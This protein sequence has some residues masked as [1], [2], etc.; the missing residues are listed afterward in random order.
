MTSRERPTSGS[1]STVAVPVWKSPASDPALRSVA[2][3]LTS[4][5]ANGWEKIL[6]LI[7]Q[8]QRPALM[9]LARQQGLLYAD[10]V[11]LSSASGS[12]DSPPPLP[13]VVDFL[14]TLKNRLDD[15]EPV[16]V[17]PAPVEDLELDLHQRL[18]VARALATPDICLILGLPGTGKSRVVA[19]IVRQAGQRNQRVLLLGQTAAALERVLARLESV[20]SIC[21]LRLLGPGETPENLPVCSRRLTL[22]ERAR[23][24]R[25]QT[26]PSARE[27]HRA[28]ELR[29]AS[30]QR[31]ADVWPELVELARQR[32]QLLRELAHLQQL[33]ADVPCA[34]EEIV[35]QSNMASASPL[36]KH[37]D[38]LHRLTH[39]HRQHQE[40]SER[41]GSAIAQAEKQRSKLIAD[42]DRVR[43][44]LQQIE[45]L[46]QA[47][48]KGRW[49]LPAWWRSLVQAQQLSRYP[50]LQRQHA[51]WQQRLQ[52]CE[53]QLQQLQREQSAAD[54]QY[55]T[56][57]QRLQQEE[58]QRRLEAL[59]QQIRNQQGALQ[60]LEERW[61][62]TSKRLL[63]PEHQP[64]SCDLS[65]IE[66]ARERWHRV[67]ETEERNA[68]CT[69]RWV[70]YLESSRDYLPELLLE[71][72]NLLAAT[73]AALTEAELNR[74][75][76]LS[77][78]FD[79][80]II[81][82]AEY[83]TEAE[84]LRLAPLGRRCVLVGEPTWEM[85]QP[86]TLSPVRSRPGLRGGRLNEE[87]KAR[88]VRRSVPPPGCFQRLW[89]T[90]HCDPS[91]LPYRWYQERNRWCCRLRE[92]PEQHQTCREIERVADQPDIELRIVVPPGQDPY[93]AE[94]VF[95]EKTTLAEA[96]TWLYRELQEVPLQPRGPLLWW[97]EKPDRLHL[98]FQE[99]RGENLLRV[100]L[101][102]GIHE[103]L[104]PSPPHPPA[105]EQWHTIR[106]E[107][108]PKL[109]WNRAR[110]EKWIS[111]YF[112]WRDRGRT[113]LLPVLYRMEP[114]L[115]S[116]VASLLAP[117]GTAW[118]CRTFPGG[119]NGNSPHSAVDFVSVP[120]PHRGRDRKER[121]KSGKDSEVEGNWPGVGAG[122]ELDLA[123][124][125]HLDRLPGELR[126]ALPNQGIVNYLEARA[127]V[128]RLEE[129]LSDPCIL[130]AQAEHGTREPVIA[131]MAFQPAQVQLLQ[132]LIERSPRLTQSGLSV[133]VGL[134][135]AFRHR[136]C[137]LAMVSL[138]RS[139][140]HRAVA[141]ADSPEALCLALTRARC[142]LVIFGDPGTLVRRGQWTGALDHQDENAAARE[143]LV[144]NQLVTSFQQRCES[145][146]PITPVDDLSPDRRRQ[147]ERTATGDPGRLAEKRSS[148]GQ[149][150]ST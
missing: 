125:R 67:Q 42:L 39:R 18:A 139:H 115:G 37:L 140:S 43:K 38:F 129:L 69:R 131:V 100:E 82:E 116:F 65:A 49:W 136:E 2:A 94:V 150:T 102:E 26:L 93:L 75:L 47:R 24:L 32:D 45:P 87:K 107:F 88:P 57:L 21:A 122:L 119:N 29:V 86:L 99:A 5:F 70:E 10:Q 6:S 9:H 12:A 7:P 16:A 127:L 72:V 89:Q 11:P 137:H 78:E 63:L 8:E 132:H 62:E 52:T 97:E 145:Q 118:P 17:E 90:L 36:P 101:T 124:R 3:A 83:L 27:M 76:G 109:G 20:E 128:K 35:R 143:A 121:G 113:A 19:E 144:V 108:D 55:R 149:G 30:L 135:S 110:A 48:Q 40:I 120:P 59:D 4:A 71:H 68:R 85:A 148:A 104:E 66:Q 98:C 73:L 60:A 84:L 146:S 58:G 130:Q 91:Q 142:R 13:G 22:A 147:A 14:K 50:E 138:T 117:T 80:V 61:K 95:P 126:P 134:P 28:A 92:V 141:L 15:L 133:E 103:I 41:L 123:G 81:E 44:E 77:K 112:P 23:G 31:E 96:R 25:E 33:R 105:P 114:P 106:L 111:E 34:V 51:E 64:A 56:H 74:T 1:L 54:E 46:V 53:Q 79:L